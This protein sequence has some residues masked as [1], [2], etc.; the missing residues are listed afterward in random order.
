MYAACLMAQISAG[1]MNAAGGEDPDG[2]TGVRGFWLL[3]RTRRGQGRVQE[4]PFRAEIRWTI[5]EAIQLLQAS[6]RA[7]IAP[8][9]LH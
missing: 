5:G 6:I 2:W 1:V 7:A 9:E 3:W 8:R 4:L